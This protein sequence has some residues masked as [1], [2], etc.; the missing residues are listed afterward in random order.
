MLICL[1]S[2]GKLFSTSPPGTW[3][4]SAISALSDYIIAKLPPLRRHHHHRYPF[5]YC[6]INSQSNRRYDAVIHMVTAAIGAERFYTTENNSVRTETPEQARELDIKVLNAWVSIFLNPI[7]IYSLNYFVFFRLVTLSYGSLT[8]VPI[9]RKR[10]T[11][12]PMSSANSLVLLG[13]QTSVGSLSLLPFKLK[14]LLMTMV[15]ASK[16]L[17]LSK[18]IWLHM[19]LEILKTQALK[20]MYRSRSPLMA[21]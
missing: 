8:T 16:L 18:F 7:F 17:R 3:L 2:S 10:S 19:A 9:S 15:F 4:S 12:L 11:A 5:N 21:D 20:R 13:P 1:V 14:N 6:F